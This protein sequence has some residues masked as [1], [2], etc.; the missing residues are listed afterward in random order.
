MLGGA[1]S[2]I[3]LGRR[4]WSPVVFWLM[5]ILI[6]A[7][8]LGQ[9]PSNVSELTVQSKF[10]RTTGG[11]FEPPSNENE[12][13]VPA[14]PAPTELT[15]PWKS[16][17]LEALRQAVGAVKAEVGS[18]TL[19][20]PPN[21]PESVP[22]RQHRIPLGE[23][24]AQNIQVQE[25]AGL[26]SL[27]VRDA[28]L[29]QVIA[30][31]AET[32]KLNIVF[33]SPAEVPVT[34]S[35]DRMPWEQVMEALL[36][37]SGHTWNMN[38]GIIYVTNIEAADFVSPQASGR[39][40]EVFE[41][42]FASAVDVDNT[43]KGLLSPAGNS[44]LVET[45][46]EDNRRT[47]EVVAVFDYPANVAR[48]SDYICQMDQPPRQVLIEANILQVELKNDCKSGINFEQISSFHG[49]ELGLGFLSAGLSNPAGTVNGPAGSSTS[50]LTVNGAALNGFL[51]LLQTTL[52][53]KTLAS[54][55]ILSV[56]GQLSR[57]QIGDQLGYSTVTTNVNQTTQQNIQFLE[58]GVIL[59]VIPRITRDGRV[60]M[61]VKPEVS[62]GQVNPNTQVPDAQTTN[63]ESNIL[64]NDGQGMV[65]GGLIQEED[66]ITENKL[67]WFG[68]LP[69]VGIL[70]QNRQ[71]KRERKEIIVTLIPHVLPYNPVIASR[72]SHDYMRT[73]DR[74]VTGPLVRVPRPYEAKLYDTFLNPRRPLATIHASHH[75][76]PMES[77]D[78]VA[79]PPVDEVWDYEFCPEPEDA[80]EI[81][82]P[83]Q[84][85]PE[86]IYQ[87]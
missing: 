84:P 15:S 29:R 26:I 75:G 10:Q 57:I 33:A 58:T 18:D 61:K 83:E 38:E 60:M 43:V 77:M 73:Q 79:L 28:P 69:Y 81:S 48:I 85:T 82:F 36:A 9:S 12:Q 86:I 45:S 51:E 76:V 71:T 6:S 64:L 65:L 37:I 52:D 68:D 54:P 56:S 74:L 30:L 44:W 70:F 27:M 7:P 62:A 1:K 53:A 42:D 20:T 32:Q 39:V 31:V 72:E 8:S 41:L 3:E 23:V 63:V 2:D 13:E 49:N 11:Q 4:A 47:R 87:Q 17:G 78:F 40:V 80:A 16:V 67:P 55:K 14:A 50:F 34:A 5:S 21:E 35:F 59:T 24:P 19:P 22:P 25:D 46:S 66:I